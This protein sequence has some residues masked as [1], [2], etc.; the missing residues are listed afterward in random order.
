MDYR[1]TDKHLNDY[2]L[3]FSDLQLVMARTQYQIHY[4]AHAQQ[5][6]RQTERRRR[7]LLLPQF[8]ILSHFSFVPSQT[9]SFALSQ[10]SLGLTKFTE[11]YINIYNI[12]LVSLDRS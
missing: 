5:H 4:L 12:K 11:K 8:Q 10:T 2:R 9:S 3:Q 6:P 7:L 1:S